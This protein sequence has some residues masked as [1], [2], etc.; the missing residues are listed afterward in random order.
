MIVGRGR[1]RVVITV[2]AGVL[3]GI[4]AASGCSEASPSPPPSSAPDP[5]FDFRRLKAAIVLSTTTDQ[6]AVGDTRGIV[7]L[8]AEDGTLSS[9]RTEGID[10]ATLARAT[11]M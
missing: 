5:G 7:Y 6:A 1:R 10:V 2:L 3:A 11:R 8:L 9:V 4:L